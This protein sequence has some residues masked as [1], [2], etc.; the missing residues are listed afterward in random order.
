M[1]FDRVDVFGRYSSAGAT[2]GIDPTPHFLNG[3]AAHPGAAGIIAIARPAGIDCMPAN[4]AFAFHAHDPNAISVGTNH[5][6][7][8]V[9]GAHGLPFRFGYRM[10]MAYA[11]LCGKGTWTGPA[12]V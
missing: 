5:T 7:I 8:P 4:V 1:V 3:S 11:K 12:Q 10:L 6:L 2:I 9:I